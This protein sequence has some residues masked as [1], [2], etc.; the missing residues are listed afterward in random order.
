M[1]N[2]SAA[3]RNAAFQ[4]LGSN[5]G[6]PMPKCFKQYDVYRNLNA[7]QR[8]GRTHAAGIVPC[9]IRMAKDAVLRS[10]ACNAL[11]F[12]FSNDKLTI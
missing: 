1:R 3:R 8:F 9:V 11:Y 6:K 5:L 2:T 12:S 7:S 10:A 4:R